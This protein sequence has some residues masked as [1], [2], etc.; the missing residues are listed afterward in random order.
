ME[1]GKRERTT[2]DAQRSILNSQ[3]SILN[4]LAAALEA[5]KAGD[6]DRILEELNRQTLEP[7]A[8]EILDQISDH[9]LMAEFGKARETIAALITKNKKEH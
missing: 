3:H 7:E 6:I 4:S 8:R 1:N 9:V 2:L 5:Q